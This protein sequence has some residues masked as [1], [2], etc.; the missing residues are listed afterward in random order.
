PAAP[1]ASAAST[2]ILVVDDNR[3]AANLLGEQ[4]AILGHVHR[5]AYDA[6]EALRIAREL[7]PDIVFLDIGLPGIDGYELAPL[8]G[9]SPQGRSM[10]LVAVTGYGHDVH[11]TGPVAALFDARLVKPVAGEQIAE[12]IERVRPRDVSRD[13]G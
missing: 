2:R 4:L 5:V 13:A 11:E 7:A 6:I 12:A 1:L 3:D 10:G 9:D 8:L